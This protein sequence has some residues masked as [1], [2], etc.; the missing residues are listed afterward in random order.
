MLT[1]ET[2][3]LDAYID[4]YTE[5]VQYLNP[6]VTRAPPTDAPPEDLTARAITLRVR[7]CSGLGVL[8]EADPVR[9]MV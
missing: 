3:T 9:R 4:R 1:Q 6:G 7:V 8:W 5:L 2:G